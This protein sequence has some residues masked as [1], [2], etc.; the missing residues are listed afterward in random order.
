M[1][2]AAAVG[3]RRGGWQSPPVNSGATK[4]VTALARKSRSGDEERKK[5]K[6]EEKRK[7]RAWL[8]EFRVRGFEASLNLLKRLPE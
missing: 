2:V 1:A 7:T 3:G 5:S 8:R 6:K 4:G